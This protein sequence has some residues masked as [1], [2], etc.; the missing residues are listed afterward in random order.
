MKIK[1][2]VATYLEKCEY[3]HEYN[4][5]YSNENNIYRRIDILR[6]KYTDF[7]ITNDDHI[8]T[9][10]CIIDKLNKI[11]IHNITLYYEKYD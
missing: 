5:A 1:Y 11:F 10:I 9:F 6:N 8:T 7:M 4:Y 2:N 3:S